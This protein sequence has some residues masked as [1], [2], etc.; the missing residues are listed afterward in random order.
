M[1]GNRRYREFWNLLLDAL[2]RS[3]LVEVRHILIEHALE[4]LLVKDE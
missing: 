3:C 1:K 4:P 2:V